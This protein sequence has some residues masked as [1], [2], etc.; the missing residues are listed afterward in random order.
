MT[1]A[2]EIHNFFPGGDL[3]SRPLQ[4]P[5]SGKSGDKLMDFA[6]LDGMILG[7]IYPLVMSK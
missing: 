5:R 7:K 1:S 4:D 3:P 2:P 6:D